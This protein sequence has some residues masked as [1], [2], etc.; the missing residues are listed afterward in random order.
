MACAAAYF[1]IGI[2]TALTISGFAVHEELRAVASAAAY[3]L[4]AYGAPVV[5][6]LYS[7][8]IRGLSMLMAI[9]L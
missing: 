4:A 9:R 1:G 5:V 6:G 3:V 8:L 2:C 7:S